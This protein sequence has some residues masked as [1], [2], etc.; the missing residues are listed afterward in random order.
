[1]GQF[2]IDELKK[3]VGGTDGGRRRRIEQK[4]KELSITEKYHK[5]LDK[6]TREKKLQ[7]FE[8]DLELSSDELKDLQGSI[9]ENLETAHKF[10]LS[11][12]WLSNQKEDPKFIDKK[13][14]LK[15]S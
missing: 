9:K 2:K 5:G 4:A 12:I 10:G 6:F 1:M 11:T 15:E 8:K 3:A 14:P 7:K 13:I